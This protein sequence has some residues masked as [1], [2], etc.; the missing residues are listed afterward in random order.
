[1]VLYRKILADCS[2]HAEAERRKWRDFSPGV[3]FSSSYL[4]YVLALID[5]LGCDTLD[6]AHPERIREKLGV[7]PPDVRDF[8]KQLIYTEISRQGE[9]PFF[10]AVAELV[11]NSLDAIARL[12]KNTPESGEKPKPAVRVRVCAE[13][14]V[15][16]VMDPGAGIPFSDLRFLDV[17]GLSS[18]GARIFN[19]SLE[20]G[21]VSGRFGLGGL[22]K[23]I[24]ILFDLL[25]DRHH[26]P[27][28]RSGV[29]GRKEALLSL[30]LRLGEYYMVLRFLAAGSRHSAS[31]GLTFSGQLP[32][33][34]FQ[35]SF[36]RAVM[37]CLPDGVALN[38]HGFG[39]IAEAKR[40]DIASRSG[41]G[42][43]IYIQYTAPLDGT[44]PDVTL[45]T[46]RFPE[47]AETGTC[48][49]LR[50][51]V[52][53]YLCDGSIAV[54]LKNAFR[55]VRHADIFYSDARGT[56]HVNETEPLV[57]LI[58]E[59]AFTLE[60]PRN[61]GQTPPVAAGRLAIFEEGRLIQA[62]TLDGTV[63]S[64]LT[65]TFRTLC[66][67]RERGTIRRDDPAITAMLSRLTDLFRTSGHK[68]LLLIG[69][70]LNSLYPLFRMMEPAFEPLLQT[71]KTLFQKYPELTIFPDFEELRSIR[72]AD[73]QPVFLHPDYIKKLGF[74]TRLSTE[75]AIYC[76]FSDAGSA[77][78]FRD[79]TYRDQVGILVDS[80]FFSSPKAR[81][82]LSLPLPVRFRWA[83]LGTYLRDKHSGPLPREFNMIPVNPPPLEL[84]PVEVN[85]QDD[86][87]T[88][89]LSD[90]SHESAEDRIDD[91]TENP[92]EE[93]MSNPEDDNS[94]ES[95]GDD[96]A[97][98]KTAIRIMTRY[99][100]TY[101]KHMTMETVPRS[102]SPAY[103]TDLS[104]SFNDNPTEE[105]PIS[106]GTKGYFLFSHLL[107]TLM[108][109]DI[110][111]PVS[112]KALL[113]FGDYCRN[114]DFSALPL[115]TFHIPGI[116]LI[117]LA[118]FREDN[119][120][121]DSLQHCFSLLSAFRE[122]ELDWLTF[123]AEMS[124]AC[125]ALPCTRLV[126]L[127]KDYTVFMCSFFQVSSWKGLALA[128]VENY[129][130]YF[131]PAVFGDTGL[132]LQ[133]CEKIRRVDE[134]NAV[135][136]TS[137]WLQSMRMWNDLPYL[138]TLPDRDFRLCLYGLNGYS[139]SDREFTFYTRDD[140]DAAI[141]LITFAATLFGTE[142][143]SDALTGTFHRI[144][145][146]LYP[147]MRFQSRIKTLFFSALEVSTRKTAECLSLLLT[148]ETTPFD[149]LDALGI[150][151]ARGLQQIQYVLPRQADDISSLLSLLEGHRLL[152][153]KCRVALYLIFKSSHHCLFMS[154]FTSSYSFSALKPLEQHPYITRFYRSPQLAKRFIKS[155]ANRNNRPLYFLAGLLRKSIGD[156]ATRADIY[157]CSDAAQ[158]PVIIF[159][160]N[161]PCGV[162][163]KETGFGPFVT[164]VF[165]PG[166]TDHDILSVFHD[167]MASAC[168][169]I[170]RRGEVIHGLFLE[171]NQD[172]SG[173]VYDLGWNLPVGLSSETA[174]VCEPPETGT[175]VIVTLEPGQRRSQP[176]YAAF[177]YGELVRFCRHLDG[178][179]T[180]IRFNGEKIML[181]A[182]T[183]NPL[184]TVSLPHRENGVFKGDL[185]TKIGPDNMLYR[186]GYPVEETGTA[187]TGHLPLSLRQLMAREGQGIVVL[188]PEFEQLENG[189]TPLYPELM[190]NIRHSVLK[191]ALN[192]L[193]HYLVEGNPFKNLL[194]RFFGDFR[195]FLT[196]SADETVNSAVKSLLNGLSYDRLAVESPLFQQ[197][198]AMIRALQKEMTSV[199][200]AYGST[201]GSVDM[202]EA[203]QRLSV[204]L[205]DSAHEQ[206][207]SA[208]LASASVWLS[209]EEV[210]NLVLIHMPLD[211]E[212]TTLCNLKEALKVVLQTE[213]I[214]DTSGNY[215]TDTFFRRFSCEEVSDMVAKVKGITAFPDIAARF[216]KDIH[217]MLT[218]LFRKRGIP[219]I[220]EGVI[221]LLK[222]FL[223]HMARAIWQEEIDVKLV[224]DM[225]YD[226]IASAAY[227]SN[228]VL[229]NYSFLLLEFQHF[230]H[231]LNRT[232]SSLLP[233][234][235]SSHLSL[236]AQWL[237][238]FTHERIHM[239][240]FFPHHDA[241][242]FAKLDREIQFLLERSDEV[243]AA[244]TVFFSSQKDTS[245]QHGEKS[246]SDTPGA[247]KKRMYYGEAENTFRFIKK[248]KRN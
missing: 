239:K 202:E 191:V 90:A 161:A 24:Y 117:C 28:I 125:Q 61:A 244:L 2:H 80:R 67:T 221:H 116:G 153:E 105:L 189:V 188:A 43:D 36:C 192:Y 131:S 173:L 30:D 177:L 130:D 69:L 211:R 199:R 197:A 62:F 220:E 71:V 176:F 7:L 109:Y 183:E 55:H 150:E 227:G 145:N 10:F 200:L 91:T 25:P 201:P 228:L 60:T 34:G 20:T 104:L 144:L 47:R 31:K 219:Q 37:P 64:S 51:P 68:N 27:F 214:L 181:P 212:G 23:F 75:R 190:L 195:R 226:T 232:P 107:D 21:G 44:D 88:G 39:R 203:V 165:R 240:Y 42:E 82:D 148:G 70:L 206:S 89:S 50:S 184:L 32:D 18:N 169:V 233:H 46:G 213:G 45:Q 66:L 111:E 157:F 97:A 218:Q 26:R 16:E 162:D 194:N 152:G 238:V 207:L 243:I 79:F 155:A 11:Q 83:L 230:V 172:G 234:L 6:L 101:F 241:R 204:A 74:E 87:S 134:K 53:S 142:T 217:S 121:P 123:F 40:I 137:K 54:M 154:S 166:R 247:T 132:F 113:I 235:L 124:D 12:Q 59:D 33:G 85:G 99:L 156:G 136:L 48:I 208:W 120:G 223:I 135:S 106:D 143:A 19:Q 175:A 103:E 229:V 52:I 94:S 1:M 95:S 56:T 171:K 237:E 77:C 128:D 92:A 5:T 151:L 9:H 96:Y 210:M 3:S 174:R 224:R 168:Q 127:F 35:E 84:T 231:H 242:F 198:A 236:F 15:I 49:R 182:S 72:L 185:V 133:V 158:R 186:C 13:E 187:Y 170:V 193:L 139:K 76:R 38:V 205:A 114:A 119:F 159:K 118:M 141:I 147:L 98:Q 178:N 196:E 164:P 100:E 41:R 81:S 222:G 160:H 180:D 4:D 245:G 138:L 110:T 73:S 29:N 17:P 216:T 246:V 14:G 112:E 248:E 102:F 58:K 167:G 115:T 140:Y 163:L 108:D 179:R 65:I 215:V 8:W 86:S 22:V 146:T 126:T 129:F 78:F 225:G 149:Y 122:E 209:H 93:T 57:P 63:F